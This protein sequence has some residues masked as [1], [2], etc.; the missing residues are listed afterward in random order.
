MGVGNPPINQVTIGKI[1]TRNL[2]EA[3]DGISYRNVETGRVAKGARIYVC[4][5]QGG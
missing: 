4:Y 3:A 1:R 5:E 2:L